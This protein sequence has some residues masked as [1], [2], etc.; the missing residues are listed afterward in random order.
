MNCQIR[1]LRG[2]NP[3]TLAPLSGN[4]TALYRQAHASDTKLRKECAADEKLPKLNGQTMIPSTK[5]C[6]GFVSLVHKLNWPAYT[7]L[8]GAQ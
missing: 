5:I 7:R 3:A 2:K 8:R 6:R 4:R 1:D